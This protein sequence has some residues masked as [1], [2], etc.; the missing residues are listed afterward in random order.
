MSPDPA[1]AYE[2]LKIET[3]AMFNYDIANLSLTQGL[4]LDLVSLLRL[5]VDTMQGQVLAGESVDL[6]RLVAAH[7]M[8][9]KMLPER[10]LV[11]RA[12]AAT[13]DFAG[14]KKE[15]AALLTQRA[16]AIEA[17]ELKETAR[18]REQIA[19][20]S[21][22]NA[23]LKAEQQPQPVPQK[24]PTNN[25]VPIDGTARANANRPPSHYLKDGQPREPWREGP[26]ALCA[27]YWEPPGGWQK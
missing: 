17:R 14:A 9:Q 23:R 25:V 1:A 13:H 15:L 26:G 19:Q 20:L 22:E 5:E 8:L 24:Q 11:A 21:E 6:Q 2:K 18:L 27:P 4:Q 7:G 16:S 12:P 10:A 3:A